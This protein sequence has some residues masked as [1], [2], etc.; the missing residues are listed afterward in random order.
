MKTTRALLIACLL[1]AGCRDQ[2]PQASDGAEGSSARADAARLT[3]LTGSLEAIRA[4]FNAHKHE[5]RFLTL[6]SPT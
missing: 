4:S 5:S 3:D 1:A 6:L 2:P